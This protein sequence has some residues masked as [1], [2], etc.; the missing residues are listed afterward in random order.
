MIILENQPETNNNM[1]RNF[2]I[3]EILI[4]MYFK[5]KKKINPLNK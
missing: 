1:L 5:N 3:F 4:L 2:R